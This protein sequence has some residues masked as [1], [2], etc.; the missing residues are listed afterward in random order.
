MNP[1]RVIAVR[2]TKTLYRDGDNC[3]KIFGEEYSTADVLKEALKQSRAAEAG[4]S[5]ASIH[6]VKLINGKLAI[7]SD[8]ICGETME[9]LIKKDSFQ[10]EEYIKRLVKLQCKINS[11][12]GLFTEDFKEKAARKIAASTLSEKVKLRLFYRVQ[13]LPAGVYAMHGDL[14]LD[15]VIVDTKGN[16]YAIDWGHAE[17]GLPAMDAALSYL[18]LSFKDGKEIAEKYLQYFCAETGE[19]DSYIRSLIPIAAVIKAAR[20]NADNREELWR[21]AETE[22]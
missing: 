20:S 8:Y 4:L 5:V 12:E 9:V 2:T 15:N 14:I 1:D 17:N 11:I 10:T 7:V 6:E 22:E 19:K 13:G 21:I 16:D 18:A 3:I